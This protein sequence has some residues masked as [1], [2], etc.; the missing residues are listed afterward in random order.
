MSGIAFMP[1]LQEIRNKELER[2]NQ[3]KRDLIKRVNKILED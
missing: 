3:E 1:D 2:D